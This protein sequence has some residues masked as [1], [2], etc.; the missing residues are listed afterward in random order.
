MEHSK[1][2][3]LT[4]FKSKDKDGDFAGELMFIGKPPKKMSMGGGPPHFDRKRL[5]IYAIFSDGYGDWY[6]PSELNI[7]PKSV[8]KYNPDTDPDFYGAHG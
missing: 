7:D 4:V 5:H 1:L 2:K 6:T 3:E 8:R